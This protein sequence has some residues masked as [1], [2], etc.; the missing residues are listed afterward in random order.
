MY[1]SRDEALHI[2]HR[3]VNAGRTFC[4]DRNGSNYTVLCCRIKE[5]NREGLGTVQVPK[6]KKCNSN[7]TVQYEFRLLMHPGVVNFFKLFGKL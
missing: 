3:L 1:C 5:S 2:A 4:R 7:Y 6:T